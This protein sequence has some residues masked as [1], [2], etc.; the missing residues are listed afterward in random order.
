MNVLIN[1]K[2]GKSK[3]V[4]VV[5]HASDVTFSCTYVYIDH[6]FNPVTCNCD[7]SAYNREDIDRITITNVED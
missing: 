3:K 4:V 5:A 2:D 7:V 1:F 6:A